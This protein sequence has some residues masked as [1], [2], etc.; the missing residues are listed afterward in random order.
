MSYFTEK[1]QKP[2]HICMSFPRQAARL[3]TLKN[4]SGVSEV[5]CRIAA[6][7]GAIIP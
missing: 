5:C 6:A 3:V 1:T 2:P 7:V 4:F